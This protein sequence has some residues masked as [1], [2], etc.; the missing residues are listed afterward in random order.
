[1]QLS[2]GSARESDGALVLTL[3]L[4]L[5]CRAWIQTKPG[6]P[7]TRNLVRITKYWIVSES[8]FMMV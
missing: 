7:L 5:E 8:D 4:L 1:M 3:L 2:N 6:K